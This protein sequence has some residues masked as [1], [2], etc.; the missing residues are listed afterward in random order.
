MPDVAKRKQQCLTELNLM[1][2]ERVFLLSGKGKT[3]TFGGSDKKRPV[4]GYRLTASQ[5]YI[6]NHDLKQSKPVKNADVGLQA[7]LQS[8]S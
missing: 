3:G 7:K 1:F 4:S 8:L 5:P 6:A 2:S